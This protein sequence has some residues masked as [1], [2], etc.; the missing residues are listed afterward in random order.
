MCRLREAIYGLKQSPRT[1]YDNFSE[2]LVEFGLHCVNLNT[3]LSHLPLR[4]G[5]SCL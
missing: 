4:K 1:S 2:A 5:R 3:L